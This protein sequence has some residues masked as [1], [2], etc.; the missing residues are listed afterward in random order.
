ELGISTTTL[1]RKI[2]K[3]GI[4]VSYLK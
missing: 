3:Y 4:S 1:W 2:K